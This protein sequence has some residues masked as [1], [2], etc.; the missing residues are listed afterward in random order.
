MMKCQLFY[1]TFSVIRYPEKV[2]FLDAIASCVAPRFLC[3]RSS[4]TNC[5]SE[6]E[7]EDQ[8]ES[9]VGDQGDISIIEYRIEQKHTDINACGHENKTVLPCAMSSVFETIC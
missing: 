6:N 2:A 8:K 3:D 5:T 9:K 7:F 4:L 1:W